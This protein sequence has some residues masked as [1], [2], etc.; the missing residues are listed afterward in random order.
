MNRLQKGFT[1]IEVLVVV[2]I[3]GVLM[4]LVSLLVIRAGSSRQELATQ[5]VAQ[6]YLPVFIDRYKQEFKRFPPMSTKELS[7]LP[8]WKGLANASNQTNESAE[9]LLVALRHPDFSTPLGDGD[10]G[11]DAPLGNTDDDIWN[12]VPEGS[13][14]EIAME[15]RDGY[16]HPIVYIHK[17]RYNEPVRIINEMGDEVEVSAVKK[18]NGTF[19]NPSSYQV[20]SVGENGV[21]DDASDPD[22]MDDIMNFKITEGD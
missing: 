8:R 15:I 10:L 3:L 21:Q 2:S 13:S 4:G 6:S 17:N 14:N 11:G 18:V 9:A 20:I 16:G 22:M 1:L 12:K 7:L 5:Q 19:Y